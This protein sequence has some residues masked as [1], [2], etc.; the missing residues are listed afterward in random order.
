MKPVAF[1]RSAS[2][3]ALQ[4]LLMAHA[5]ALLRGQMDRQALLAPYDAAVRDQAES[6]LA[7]AERIQQSMVRVV[8]SDQFVGRLGQLLTQESAVQSRGLWGRLRQLP[9]RTQLVAG[10]GGATLTAGLVLIASRSVPS[11]LE[12]WRNRREA[13]A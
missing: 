8:P 6:L 1:L 2:E 12:Y 13:T 11:A 5:D 9:P 3:R 4:D 10:I 7:L